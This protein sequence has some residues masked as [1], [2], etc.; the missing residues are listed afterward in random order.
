MDWHVTQLVQ[1]IRKGLLSDQ[2][3]PVDGPQMTATEIHVRTNLIL[4]ILAPIASRL[5]QEFIRPKTVREIQLL[6]D[7]NILDLG[8]LSLDDIQLSYQSP[9]AK[10]QAMQDVDAIVQ[11]QQN[12]SQLIQVY[13][14]L[15]DLYDAVAGARVMADRIG[16]MD[17]LLRTPAQLQQL[18]RQKQINQQIARNQAA[19]EELAEQNNANATPQI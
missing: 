6:A 8:D 4:R 12:M 18:Q 3:Q 11:F 15:V 9:M 14:E 5:E 10:A 13:P 19:Q 1:Q 17:G 7:N 2:L 16:L